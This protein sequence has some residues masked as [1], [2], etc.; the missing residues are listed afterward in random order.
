MYTAETLSLKE[1]AGRDMNIKAALGEEVADGKEKFLLETKM[2]LSIKCWIFFAK[3]LSAVGQKI[4][5]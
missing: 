3:L 5:L 1:I 2:F 4:K